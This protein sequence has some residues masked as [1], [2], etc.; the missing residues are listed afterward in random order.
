MDQDPR[1][2]RR[3]ST[4]DPTLPRNTDPGIQHQVHEI[5]L[6]TWIRTVAP[7]LEPVQKIRL[8]TEIRILAFSIRYRIRR[9]DSPPKTGYWHL[10]SGTEDPTLHRNP[11]PGIQ[12]QVQKIRLSSEIRI[13]AFSIRYRRYNSPPK[14]GSWH[15]AS[16]TEDTTV[17]RNLDPGI[18]HQVPLH[19]IRLS[20]WI[21]ILA[22]SVEPVQKIRLSPEIRILAFSIRYHYMRSDSPPGRRILARSV[23]PVQKIQLSTEIRILALSIRYRRSDS[24]AKSGSWH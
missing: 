19:E 15:S 4:E 22:P 17:L 23:E 11:D 24:L 18:Q 3:A 1:P 8:S 13:L 2:Q 14:S 12:H 10:A 20:T 9:S 7:S 5:R 6:S 16:G 21:R